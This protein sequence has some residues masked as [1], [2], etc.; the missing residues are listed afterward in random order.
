MKDLELVPVITEKF[1][2]E[3]DEQARK[4]A[5]ME[6]TIINRLEY[7]MQFAFNLFNQNKAYWYF[8]DAAE[9]EVGSLWKSYNKDQITMVVC[10]CD[11]LLFTDKDDVDGDLCHDGVQTRWL[12]EHFEKEFVDGKLRYE[13]KELERK[14][15]QKELSAKKKKKDQLLIEQ[16]KKKLSTEELAAIKRSL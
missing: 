13:Q 14:S 2:K 11:S 7:I 12:F 9:G 6:E 3:A 15:R 10:D 8:H 5:G 4:A 16:V 1:V